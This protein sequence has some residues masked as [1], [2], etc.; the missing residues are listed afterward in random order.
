MRVSSAADLHMHSRASD[1]SDAPEAF[2]A[3]AADL[4]VQVFSLTDHDTVSGGAKLLDIYMQGASDS[5][6]GKNHYRPGE[7]V[8]VT[9]CGAS[10]QSRSAG[11]RI[12]W[13]LPG[14]E[15]S[16]RVGDILCHLLGYCYDPDS[17]SIA[18]VCEELE[19]RR[20][21]KMEIRIDNLKR[22][23]GIDLTNE[24]KDW[25]FSM[26]SPG[27]PHLAR[28]LMRRGLASSVDDAFSRYLNSA[29]SPVPFGI[30]RIEAAPA[31]EAVKDAGG[32]V[33]WAHPLGGESD[34]RLGPQEL[35]ERL[36]V[37]AG[38]GIQD[39]ECYYSRYS[40]QE[41][42][43]LANQAEKYGLLISG[44]SDYHGIN[45]TV[46]AGQLRRDDVPVDIS[47][48]TLLQEVMDI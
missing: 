36:K 10:L 29:H 30:S 7:A 2:A 37:L 24:E 27:R 6:G 34:R 18:R 28:V 33:G 44:G 19:R 17:P 26:E 15:L 20:I 22:V 4:G 46:L 32:I 11:D 3:M 25:I 1:G 16:C 9:V 21:H 48:L 8:G 40:A 41:E 39:L 42:L 43:F 31:I 5:G 23:D 47:G 14:V 35:K 45:K 38:L 12:I 13:F